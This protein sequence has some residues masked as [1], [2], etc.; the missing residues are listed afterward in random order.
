MVSE[1]RKDVVGSKGTDGRRRTGRVLFVDVTLERDRERRFGGKNM[2]KYVID[3]KLSQED[4]CSDCKWMG[5]R[6]RR[7]D[8]EK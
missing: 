1:N 5:R 6:V 7:G 4:E 8:G 2:I 3:G